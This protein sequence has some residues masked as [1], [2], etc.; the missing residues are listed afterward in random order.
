MS[1][2]QEFV[3]EHEAVTNKEFDARN[4]LNNRIFLEEYSET[5]ITPLDYLRNI[6]SNPLQKLRAYLVSL[7]PIAQWILHYNRQ[8]LA[9]DLIAGI[10]VG[11]V[12]VPQSMSYAQ[13]AGLDAQY[14]LYSSFVGVFIYCF[15][16]TS[17]DVSIGPVAVMSGQVGRVIAKVQEEYPD[18]SAPVIATFLSLICGSVAI[19]LGLLR[20]GFI[21]EYIPT[22][23]VYA[24]MTGSAL[25]IVSGQV[26]LLM[27]YNKAVNTRDSTYMVIINTLKHLPDTKVD[28][29]F[30][31]V[32][33][34]VLY[35]WKFGCDFAIKRFPRYKKWFFYLQVIRHAFVIVIATLISWGIAHPFLKRHPGE[36]TPFSV[37]GDVPSGLEH[38][39]VMTIPSK[40][41]MSSVASEIPVCVIVLLLEHISISK[42]FGRLND[43]T[44]VPDQ[45]MIAIGVT[46]LIGT[47]FN[48]YPATG[49]FSRSALKSKS[50]VRTPFAGI[51]TGAVVIL[52]LYCFTLAFYYIPKLALSAII[53]HCVSDLVASYKVTWNLYKTSPLDCGI[54]LI[55]VIICVFS[56]MENGIYFAA[57][58]SV[59]VILWRL[60]K[61]NAVF[62]GKVQVAEVIN[63]KIVTNNNFEESS[64]SSSESI[65]V[66]TVSKKSVLE[67]TKFDSSYKDV[68]FHHKWVPIPAGASPI[69][70][71]MINK[72][73]EIVP[74]PPGVF[75]FRPSESFTYPN[76]SR[77]ADLI[78]NVIKEHT[79]AHESRI[80]KTIGDRPWND[81]PPLVFSKIPVVEAVRNLFH[82]NSEEDIYTESDNSLSSQEID[83]RPYLKLIHFDFSM[84]TSMDST[85]VMLLVD[86]RRAVFRYS[87]VDVEYHFSG[88][89]SPWIRRSLIAAGFGVPN[90]DQ[91]YRDVEEQVGAT[92]KYT[93]VGVS[94]S[95]S[96]LVA[97]LD[98]H[99]PFFHFD[100]PDYSD[101]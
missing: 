27:G 64:Q 40:G 73:I 7:F 17:K 3:S 95:G 55:G 76:S 8:W 6:F 34:V 43:Y 51:F 61:P 19:G 47:F 85:S 21:L 92:T 87:G 68:K 41:I 93:D 30:G 29:A 1:N 33:L 44:V 10:T 78:L 96:N 86:L 9:G 16:A 46:N 90:S 52:A 84:V 28:L 69:H 49:S 4:N 48:A 53:I 97:V 62:L 14:G 72:D 18:A 25:N 32:C 35:S 5:A 81:T 13:L 45:E 57:C 67:K 82:K 65:E 98:T 42:S 101:Y 63:P 59:A 54:F 20:L 80:Y 12:L 37:I 75:V 24:F 100:I 60:S 77:Q 88:I 91:K 39:G 74:P 71:T 31:L 26:P 11:V 89:L 15:F 58:A 38:T 36:K 99:T 79:K 22:P 83:S 2:A 94:S 50:G 56:S 66:Q 23:A 70:T